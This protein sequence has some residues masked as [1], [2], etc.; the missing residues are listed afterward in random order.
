MDLELP[1]KN[2]KTPSIGQRLFK[3]SN[4]NL[5]KEKDLLKLPPTNVKKKPVR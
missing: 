4:K 2:L 3:I 1:L 5:L